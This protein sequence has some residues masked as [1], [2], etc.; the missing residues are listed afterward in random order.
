MSR[1]SLVCAAFVALAFPVLSGGCGPAGG[2]GSGT[3]GTTGGSAGSGRPWRRECGQCRFGRDDGER[4]Q[5]RHDRCRWRRRLGRNRPGRV[6][7]GRPESAGTSGS[8]GIREHGRQGRLRRCRRH[9]R[10]GTGD[11]GG[12]TAGTGGSSAGSGGRGGSGGGAGGGAGGRGGATGGS[13]GGGAGG[14]AACTPIA[15]FM[16]WPAGKGPTDIGRLGVHRFQEFTPTT[17]TG[18]PATRWCSPG[19]A[20]CGSR[21]STATP[22]DNTNLITAFEPYATNQRTVDNSATAT[23]I[24]AS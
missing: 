23:V 17:P 5:L 3:A 4:R 12:A 6:P 11:R 24:C 22:P 13:G 10:H 21:R 20:R 9:G 1:T 19:S 16:T 18:A 2:D 8:G 7:P 14:A 15:D